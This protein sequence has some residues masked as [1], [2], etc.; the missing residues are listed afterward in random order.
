MVYCVFTIAIIYVDTANL[1]NSVSSIL[2]LHHYSG[3]PAHFSEYNSGG[4]CQCDA[5]TGSRKSE[6][7]YHDVR[8]CLKFPYGLV[9]LC[10]FYLPVNSDVGYF[11]FDN[12]IFDRIHH[13]VVMSENYELDFIFNQI[14]Q[15]FYHPPHFSQASQTV[16]IE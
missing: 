11:F 5:L 10:G 12:K 14:F 8:I 1:P 3:S 9:P 2:G 4:C 7:T 15:K 13:V 6:D 16:G